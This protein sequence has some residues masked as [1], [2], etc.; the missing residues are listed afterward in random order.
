MIQY[1]HFY[2]GEI[3]IVITFMDL[4]TIS[5]LTFISPISCS[6]FVALYLTHFSWEGSCDNSRKVRKTEIKI[7][8]S[9]NYSSK[10]LACLRVTQ[11][12]TMWPQN[13]MIWGS[14]YAFKRFRSYCFCLFSKFN[15]KLFLKLIST[16][17]DHLTSWKIFGSNCSTYEL[18]YNKINILIVIK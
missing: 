10:Q 6:F 1:S 9:N 7:S 8:K 2:A 11:S 13:C 3:S 18:P 15:I 12:N 14:K 17:I 4:S 16:S 5:S